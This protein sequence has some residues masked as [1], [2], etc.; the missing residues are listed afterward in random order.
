MSTE[1]TPEVQNKHTLELGELHARRRWARPAAWAVLAALVLGLA[2]WWFNR[3]AAD[4]PRYITQE[5]TRGAITVTVTAT[6]NLEPV[7]QVDIGSELSGTVRTVNADVNDRVR[8]GDVLATLD[9]TRLNAQVLQAESSLASAQARV[10]QSDASVTEARA[11]LARLQKVRELSGG[12]LPSQQDFDV[13][14]A[15]RARAEGE[16]A[17]ARAAVAQ[18]RATLEAVRTDLEK[19]QIRSPI[20]GVVLVRSVEPGQTVA[21]SLQAPVLFTLAED[22]KQMELHVAVDEADVGSVDVGQAATFTVDAF[23]NRSFEARISQVHFASNNTQKSSSSTTSAAS[24]TSTGVVT[25]ETVLT[26]TNEELLLRPGMTATAE[27]VTTRIDDALLVPNAALRFTPDEAPE[28][29]RGGQQRSPLSALM[30]RMPRRGSAQAQGGGRRTARVWTI[31]NGKPAPI[32]FRP[33][34]SDGRVTQV[35]ESTETAPARANDDAQTREA[36]QRTL[37]PGTALIVDAES[38]R[39]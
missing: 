18:A 32:Q 10:L 9:T 3:G 29:A 19:A 36:L 28:D 17:A 35:L 1:T 22:L 27:I 26:V 23:P 33:G 21:A 8:R 15:A 2:L 30:P 24:A 4:A 39:A 31:E 11:N 34:A 7:N 5:V 12:K 14:E 6:G 38:P 20:D 37:V 25:Y 13:A 16:A